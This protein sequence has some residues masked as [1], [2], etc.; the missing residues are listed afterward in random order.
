VRE[1][2]DEEVVGSCNRGKGIVCT[3]EG[4]DI[5]IVEGRKR[6]GM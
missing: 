6:R 5:F 4:K 1:N 2:A 3:E